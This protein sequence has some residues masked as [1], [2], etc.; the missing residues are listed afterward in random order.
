M[1]DEWKVLI[2]VGIIAVSIFAGSYIFTGNGEGGEGFTGG[3]GLQ[4]I[5]P[6]S[7]S[8]VANQLGFGINE[9]AIQYTKKGVI[10]IRSLFGSDVYG[11]LNKLQITVDGLAKI[12]WDESGLIPT[13]HRITGYWYT[14]KWRD[15][16]TS[17]TNLITTAQSSG[18][19]TNGYAKAIKGFGKIETYF[20]PRGKLGNPPH[21]L[22]ADPMVLDF[23]L[24]PD[25]KGIAIRVDFH[26]R[27]DTGDEFVCQR[28][29]AFVIH[30]GF[31]ITVKTIPNYCMVEFGY[32]T[33]HGAVV[34]DTK[35]SDGNG[36]V[37]FTTERTGIHYVKVSR[38]GMKTKEEVF[39]VTGH[40]TVTVDLESEEP[41]TGDET[42]TITVET[43][44][45][46]VNVWL[47]EEFRHAGSEGKVVFTDIA[48]GT[49]MLTAKK[50]ITWS[51]STQT[52]KVTKDETFV[53]TLEE[54]PLPV[55]HKPVASSPQPMVETGITGMSTEFYVEATDEDGDP[56]QYRIDFDDGTLSDWTS[57]SFIS[58]IYLEAG[59]YEVKTKAY[60]GKEYSSWSAP[61]YFT[62]YKAN[63]PPTVTLYGPLSGD[64]G[65]PGAEYEF[66]AYMDD[67]N[68]DLL[69]VR[70]IWDDGTQTGWMDTEVY[71][72]KEMKI[73]QS[74]GSFTVKIEVYDGEFYAEDSLVFEVETVGNKLP[75]PILTAGDSERGRKNTV[76]I[77][78]VTLLDKDLFNIFGSVIDESGVI[79]KWASFRKTFTGNSYIASMDFICDRVG[80]VA[81]SVKALPTASGKAIGYSSSDVATETIQCKFTIEEEP[82]EPED[83]WEWDDE[84]ED[85]IWE[86]Y[87]EE[88]LVA[89]AYDPAKNTKKLPI[90]EIIL[91]LSIV[92]IVA[93]AIVLWRRRK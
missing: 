79:V 83:E 20:P 9:N 68:N 2:V 76:T 15:K 66:T 12:G 90:F 26:I 52:I 30:E 60:D 85:I 87:E 40:M 50:D 43:N 24:N 84:M 93:V 34:L 86:P 27:L 4:S 80:D 92:I 3:F 89:E 91:A 49:H 16:T 88:E 44:V 78:V 59:D 58:H 81:I 41:G 7:A 35:E 74:T 61:T 67:I 14:V 45:A 62:V 46:F 55:N 75:K 63:A 1:D 25:F 57:Y 72:M 38:A 33:A 8:D 32:A 22:Y 5:Q 6:Q 70:F 21:Y 53:V 23:T 77:E 56:L 73:Y 31:H 47:D 11:G 36:I 37:V 17:W 54:I 18:S 42:Y 19:F 82:E 51:E 69:E 64:S 28:E 71:V 29:E 13:W 48:Y 39:D 10:G 65:L